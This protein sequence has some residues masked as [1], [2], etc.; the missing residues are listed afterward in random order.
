[1]QRSVRPSPTSPSVADAARA[2]VGAVAGASALLVTSA[3]VRRRR[4]TA[5]DDGHGGKQWQQPSE[6]KHQKQQT[7]GAYVY[8]KKDANEAGVLGELDPAVPRRHVAGRVLA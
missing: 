2:C 6:P 4:R 3:R 5:A 1:M 7:T 8:L